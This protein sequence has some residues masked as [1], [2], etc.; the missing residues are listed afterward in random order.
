MSNIW[1]DMEKE[2]LSGSGNKIFFVPGEYPL[3]KIK[4]CRHVEQS[5]FKK[6]EFFLALIEVLE[7]NVESR[8]KGTIIE[9]M[10]MATNKDGAPNTKFRANV[11]KLLMAAF[12]TTDPADVDKDL[13]DL[14]VD[15]KAQAAAGKYLS[16]VA[17]N[18][19]LDNGGKFTVLEWKHEEARAAA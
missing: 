17:T 18:I 12:N 8:P 9:Y 16:A 10:V 5:R 6:K 11:K 3:L 15:E 13:V 4:E 7:S 2:D 1:D 19:D 14:V